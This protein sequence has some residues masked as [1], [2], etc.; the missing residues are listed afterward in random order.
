MEFTVDSIVEWV[1]IPVIRFPIVVVLPFRQYVSENLLIALL[2]Y[3]VVLSCFLRLNNWFKTFGREDWVTIGKLQDPVAVITGGSNGL[4]NALIL[5]LL[6][7]Y[8]SLSIVNL[9]KTP[10]KAEDDKLQERVVYCACDLLDTEQLNE[11]LVKLREEYGERINLIINNAGFRLPYMSCK[12]TG[13]NELQ[14]IMQVNSI[15][16]VRIIQELVKNQQCY[17]VNVASALGIL[18]PAKVAG[19]AASKAASIAFHHSYSSELNSRG[20]SK[21]RT[22]LVL[23][24]QLDTSMFAGFNPPRKFWAPVVSASHLAHKIIDCCNV[25]VR[26]TLKDPFYVNFAYILMSMPYMVQNI[27]RVVARMDDCLPTE[28]IDNSIEQ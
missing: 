8:P 28:R 3:S 26:G 5:E 17:I 4:G 11:T 13:M 10:P 6:S 23:P 18:A 24:G 16:P 15:S 22:L 12:A 27:V 1:V 25:G 20:I 19:Y 9:D 2:A 14:D 7:K 21:V